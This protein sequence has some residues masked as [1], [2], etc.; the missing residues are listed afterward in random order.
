MRLVGRIAATVLLEFVACETA[1]Q[2]RRNDVSAVKAAAR[3]GTGCRCA[4]VTVRAEDIGAN[5]SFARMNGDGLA[6]R[7]CYAAGR[8]NVP[9]GGRG[10]VVTMASEGC[11]RDCVTGPPDRLW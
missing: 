6:R 11:H 3:K 7:R 4:G 1:T 2:I 5:L 8:G 9:L 10:H